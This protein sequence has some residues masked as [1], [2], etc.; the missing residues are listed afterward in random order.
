[1][2]QRPPT[3]GIVGAG[4]LARMM[5][6]A[7]IP[8][9]IRIE[10]L[11]ASPDDGAA[12]VATH[13]A[14]GDPGSY[15]AV[16]ALAGR[17]DVTTFDHELVDVPALE[18]IAAAGHRLHPGPATMAIAQDKGLQHDTFAAAG[19]PLPRW[20]R[21]RSSSDLAAFEDIAGG[22]LVLKAER[23]GYDGRG[24]W[25]VRD[26][27]TAS[28]VL[29]EAA[30]RGIPLLAEEAVALD[31]EVAVMVVRSPSGAVVTYPVVETVQ[32]D[33]ILHELLVPAPI[34]AALAVEAREL[35]H[36]IADLVGVTGVMAVE[37]FVSGGRLLVNE[38]A[39]RPHNS[40]HYSI[41]GAVT[42]QFDNHL[43][44]VLDWPL[45]DTTPT[46]PAIVTA[47]V[48][49]REDTPDPAAALPHVLAIQG[50]HPHLYGKTPRP[51]R[52]IGHVT[53]AGSDPASV[54]KRAIRAAGLLSGAIPLPAKQKQEA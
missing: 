2:T 12:Q 6:Q 44:A 32:R 31:R 7:A 25:L 15:E 45:G 52:K 26:A 33:G 27:S 17:S 28:A 20:Q 21:V 41:E 34:P 46:A 18:R 40:G 10:L 54:R 29:D 49:G 35:A 48:L 30:R 38:I 16:L 47:N 37:M 23:G 8:L 13:V 36:R 53:V 51:G 24:V 39:T 9:G 43:R 3:V 1:M 22:P 4:Q 42:S 11:A 14:V 5:I 19:L 50:A